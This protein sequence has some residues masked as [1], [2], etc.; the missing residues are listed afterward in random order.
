MFKI[1]FLEAERNQTDK[2][3]HD[4]QTRPLLKDLLHQ[5]ELRKPGSKAM[6]HQKSMQVLPQKNH[7]L[8]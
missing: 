3:S 2:K 8:Q 6:S 4:G 5:P 1:S 7:H